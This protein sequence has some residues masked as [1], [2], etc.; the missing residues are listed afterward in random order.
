MLARRYVLLDEGRDADLLAA[1]DGAANKAEA[2]RALMRAGLQAQ[3]VDAGLDLGA[4]VEAMRQVVREE[5]AGLSLAAAVPASGPGADEEARR[6]VTALF[7]SVA[8]GGQQG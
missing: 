2:M 3:R 5:L 1:I 4:V 6:K 7:R 8:P